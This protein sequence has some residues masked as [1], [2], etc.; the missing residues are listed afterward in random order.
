MAAQF[1]RTAMPWLRQSLSQFLGEEAH[2]PLAGPLANQL[3]KAMGLE[4][5]NLGRKAF[6]E[7]TKE[8]ISTIVPDTFTASAKKAATTG[9][10]KLSGDLPEEATDI[11]ATQPRPQIFT[12][13]LAVAPAKHA[14][15]GKPILGNMPDL[16]KTLY[17]PFS[18]PVAHSFTP[19]RIPSK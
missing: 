4:T 8:S 17:P 14:I 15:L 6:Q 11:A 7:A 9:I 10:K 16:S 19:Y 18:L 13:F 12:S 2:A 1:G 5:R 3:T